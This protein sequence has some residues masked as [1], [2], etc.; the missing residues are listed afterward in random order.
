MEEKSAYETRKNDLIHKLTENLTQ[1]ANNRHI[2]DF[3]LDLSL[4]KSIE[5]A[6]ELRMRL[7]PLGVNHLRVVRCLASI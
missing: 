2:E 1:L 4:L 6:M 3:D 7:E 5:G